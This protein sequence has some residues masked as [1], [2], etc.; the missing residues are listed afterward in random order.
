MTEKSDVSLRISFL[1]LRI[2][3]MKIY[4]I[5]FLAF[6][7]V[8]CATSGFN[9]YFNP[10]YEDNFFPSE[11][12]LKDG[13]TPAIISTS[14]LESKY[15]EIAS[16]WFWCIGYSGFNGPDLH[17]YEIRDDL[18]R[19]GKRTR[20]KVIA[21]SKKYTDTRSGA[22]TLPNTKYHS[23]ID[24]YGNYHSYTTTSYSTYSYSVQ[25]YDY[26]A[27]LFVPIPREYRKQYA[28]GF[29]VSNLSQKDRERYQRN[30]GCL[31]NIVY[32]NSIAYYANI[33]HGD[34]ITQINDKRIYSVDDF[35]AVRSKSRKGDLWD[36]TIIRNGYPLQVVLKYGY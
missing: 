14:D 35:F 27:Y 13:E 17:S 31:V 12:Y 29:S 6:L 4:L 24:F 10:W 11:A 34:V 18:V 15:R 25:R 32:K 7:F 3:K 8:G 23:Y 28:P 22:Y 21:W 30:T 1:L 5:G 36:M 20:A 26:S 33:L 9:D 2:R 19:L 16:N